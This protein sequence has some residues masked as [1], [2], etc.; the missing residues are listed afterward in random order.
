MVAGPE[1]VA[2]AQ[3]FLGVARGGIPDQ[4]QGDARGPAGPLAD[5]AV[6]LVPVGEHRCLVLTHVFLRE[7]GDA[8]E[9]VPRAHIVVAKPCLVEPPTVE[10]VA[11]VGEIENASQAL[12]LQVPQLVGWEVLALGERAAQPR[13]GTPHL[14]S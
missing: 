10:V 7:K 3:R 9:V 2:V 5:H 6:A 12:P 4:V 11:P 8:P 1:I 14:R 13:I